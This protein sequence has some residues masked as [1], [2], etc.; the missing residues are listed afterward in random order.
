[1]SLLIGAAVTSKYDRRL[2]EAA[3]LRAGFGCGMGGV[4]S[5]GGRLLPFLVPAGVGPIISSAYQVHTVRPESKGGS[6]SLMA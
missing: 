3:F 6:K 2:F 1:M 4:K 5:V